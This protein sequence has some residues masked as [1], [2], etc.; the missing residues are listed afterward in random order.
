M[1][2][3]KYFILLFI[4]IF[5]FCFEYEEKIYL[6]PNLA[7]RV[8]LEYVIPIDKKSGVSLIS[9]FPE[10]QEKFK[11]KYNVEILSFKEESVSPLIPNLNYKKIKIEFKFNNIIDLEKKLIGENYITI[12]G[13]RVFIQRK[14]KVPRYKK[15]ENKI[16][17]YFYKIVY[18]SY[19]AKNLKFS[20]NTPTHFD[21][22]TNLGNLPLPG[23]VYN[24]ISLDKI[25]ESNNEIVWNITIK[26]NPN[27]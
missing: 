6:N 22:I 10:S 15:I 1:I 18:D 3:K 26:I 4:L 23:I 19:K 13:N 5:S 16:Y 2:Y 20:L 9:F 12:N 14:F 7:G 21:V 11:N 24:Q 8:I 17:N 27:P 25:L